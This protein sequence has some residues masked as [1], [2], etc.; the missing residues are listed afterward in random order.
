MLGLYLAAAMALWGSLFSLNRRAR[1][2]SRA[3]ETTLLFLYEM[4]SKR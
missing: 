4:T 3:T 1:G 2:W